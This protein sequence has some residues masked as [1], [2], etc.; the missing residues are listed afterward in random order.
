MTEYRPGLL[1]AHDGVQIAT[2][3]WL[4]ENGRPR[5]LV[6]IAHGEGE[7]AL[8]YDGFAQH[9]VARGYGVLATDHRGHGAT[10][11]YTGGYGVAEAGAGDDANGAAGR[12]SWRAIVEDLKTAGDQARTLHPGVP[13]VL[14]GH[15]LG[16]MLARDY[17]QE[18]SDGLAGL[19]LTG[20]FRTL[21][22]VDIEQAVDRLEREC[23]EAG[24]AAPSTYFSELFGTFNDPFPYRTG[25]EWLSRDE[26]QV[27]AYVVDERCGF[28]L[29]AGLA[30][31][32]VRAIRKIND[33]RNLVR[34]PVD[35]PVHIAVGANDPCNLWLTLL[36]ELLEDFR[37]IGTEDLT[38]RSYPGARHEL[39]NET[40]RI[41]VREDLTG[42]LDRH[43]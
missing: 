15:S 30:L 33:P 3:T 10:A 32:W 25:F 43:V 13:V 35:L 26:S 42:W 41:G 22:G 19:I 9:L 2:Y 1:H 4:P 17:A 37:Y 16:S 38:W 40:N 27:D 8:R 31:D 36:Y 11:Q 20:T 14:L 7:H 29:S 5:A 23:A 34:I 12:G 18:Y 28:P 6:Q 21:P 39:L 24:R